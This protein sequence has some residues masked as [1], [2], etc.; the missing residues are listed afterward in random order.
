MDEIAALASGDPLM[1]ERVTLDAED[2]LDYRRPNSVT[3][4]RTQ[5]YVSSWLNQN[6]SLNAHQ[7]TL[8]R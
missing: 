1:L 5:Q 2:S 4:A 3:F 6:V 7:L 8:N